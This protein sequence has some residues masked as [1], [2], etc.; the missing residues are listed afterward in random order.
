MQTGLTGLLAGLN[1]LDAHP[2]RIAGVAIYPYWETSADEWQTYSE[3]W[4]GQ[5][6]P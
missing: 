2:E 3:L 4:L 1:D 5:N 6:T